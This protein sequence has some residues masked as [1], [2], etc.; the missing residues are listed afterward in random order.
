[1]QVENL[2]HGRLQICAI[3]D[4]VYCNPPAA[5]LRRLLDQVHRLA[6]AHTRP[7]HA[8]FD[9]ANI[10]VI[11]ELVQLSVLH[12]V[13]IS[14]DLQK[15]RLRKN[16]CFHNQCFRQEIRI[17][18]QRFRSGRSQQRIKISSL[19]LEPVIVSVFLRQRCSIEP[20]HL[21][22]KANHSSSQLQSGK[23]GARRY[24]RRR[25]SFARSRLVRH[26]D[27]EKERQYT[28]NSHIA[29]H[30]RPSPNRKGA[31]SET[32]LFNVGGSD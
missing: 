22:G 17:G 23:T 2:R 20:M 25:S 1:M 28:S 9:R 26:P 29:H 18:Q 3:P 30:T 7:G 27:Q 24:F 8:R 15:M 31:A 6:A 5:S 19:T 11:V 16:S 21:F 32:S 13:K 14:H 12:R 10:A 4:P